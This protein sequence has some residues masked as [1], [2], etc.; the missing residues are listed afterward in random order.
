FARVG[1]RLSPYISICCILMAVRHPPSPLPKHAVA[2]A[3]S[4]RSPWSLTKPGAKRRRER[5]YVM[6]SN[7][8]APHGTELVRS[9]PMARYVLYPGYMEFWEF[10]RIRK[11]SLYNVS[12]REYIIL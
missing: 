10:R 1:E 2:D 5:A 9:L 12:C 6:A 4:C 7:S 8:I 3:D 11:E